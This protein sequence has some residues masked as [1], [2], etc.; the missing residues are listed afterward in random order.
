MAQLQYKVQQID[1]DRWS[2]LQNIIAN[3]SVS[4]N[5]RL[6]IAVD[7]LI[8]RSVISPQ[9]AYQITSSV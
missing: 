1:I 4:G 9:E 8:N 3:I 5:K 2:K 6:Y 7:P